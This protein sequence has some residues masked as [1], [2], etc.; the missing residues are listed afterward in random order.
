MAAHHMAGRKLRGRQGLVADAGHRFGAARAER[1]AGGRAGGAWRLTG[2]KRQASGVF[3]CGFGQR[4][5]K[6]LRVRVPG[7]TEQGVD[8]RRLHHLPRVQNQHPV[9]GF[10]HNA[11]VVRNQQNRHASFA[12]NLADKGQYLRLHRH[13]QRRSRLVGQQ[14]VRRAGKRHRD[15]HPLAHPAG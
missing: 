9:A 15:H 4:G 5:Q 10:S 3:R 2:D 8:I 12:P 7:V 14:H 11:Q 6:S 13:I 1:A